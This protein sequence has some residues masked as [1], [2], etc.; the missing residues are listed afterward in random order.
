MQNA[1]K[2]IG[3]KDGQQDDL[4]SI[5]AGILHLGNVSFVNAGGAQVVDIYGKVSMYANLKSAV[6]SVQN[7]Q[8]HEI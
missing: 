4:R 1:L 6:L 8:V 2:V 3:F 7:N 5:L